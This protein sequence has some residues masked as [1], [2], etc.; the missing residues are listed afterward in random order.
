MRSSVPPIFFSVLFGFFLVLPGYAFHSGGVAECG[1]CHSMHSPNPAGSS[2]LIG[3]DQ[4]STCL[5]CHEH[6][7]DASPSGYHIS[8]APADMA[9]GVPP[10]QRTPGGDFGWL[11]KNYMFVVRGATTAEG[12]ATHGHNI[13]AADFGYVVDPING[14]SPGGPSR[15]HSL[16]ATPATIRTESTAG[17]AQPRRPS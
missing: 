14:T 5:S 11:K 13:V 9:D 8:T 17:P 2:L 4:S 6:A 1:G 16:P 10:K 12:G 15:P 3:S 7:G